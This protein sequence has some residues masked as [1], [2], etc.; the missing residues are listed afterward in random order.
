MH[1]LTLALAVLTTIYIQR[2]L[3]RERR[4][5]HSKPILA[6]FVS[7]KRNLPHSAGTN[8][9]TLAYHYCRYFTHS[10]YRYYARRK[11]CENSRFWSAGCTA[12]LKTGMCFDHPWVEVPFLSESLIFAAASDDNAWV[13]CWH[14]QYSSLPVLWFPIEWAIYI[15]NLPRV[16]GVRLCL[17]NTF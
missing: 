15:G 10:T 14:R 4:M 1:L 9:W 13:V 6:S 2:R 5:S 16:F 11:W 12:K 17:Q 7:D 3:C 8:S